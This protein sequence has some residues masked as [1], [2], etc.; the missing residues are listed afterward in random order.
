MCFLQFF[1]FRTYQAFCVS[2]CVFSIKLSEFSNLSFFFFKIGLRGGGIVVQATHYF[3]LQ[4]KIV[5]L[6]DT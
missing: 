5:L 2:V 1:A 3:E 6:V 4:Y